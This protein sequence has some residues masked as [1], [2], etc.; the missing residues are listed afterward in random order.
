[1]KIEIDTTKLKATKDKLLQQI[2][3]NP[4]AAAAIGAGLL[5][6][7]AALMNASTRRRNSKTAAKSSQTWDREV[8]RRERASS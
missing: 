6:G 2:A 4:I 3:E 8:A 5:N 7:S 1:M